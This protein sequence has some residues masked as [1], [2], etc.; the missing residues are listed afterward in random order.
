MQATTTS[1][2][3]M[4]AC[5]HLT[6]WNLQIEEFDYEMEELQGNMKKKQK[7]PPRLAELEELIGHYKEHVDNLEKVLRC[8]DNETIQPDELEDLKN[9]LDSYLVSG[10]Y[11]VYMACS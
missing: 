3:S 1:Q 11:R 4:Q 9:D 10:F 8:I 6:C 5:H 2:T 7:P